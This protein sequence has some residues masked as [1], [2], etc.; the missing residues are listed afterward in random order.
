LKKESRK[1]QVFACDE[2]LYGCETMYGDEK[3]ICSNA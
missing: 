3:K 2:G 1:H